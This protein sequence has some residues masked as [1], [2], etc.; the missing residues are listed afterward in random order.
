MAGIRNAY[1]YEGYEIHDMS[2][3][4]AF[5]CLIASAIDTT[6]HA[7]LIILIFSLQKLCPSDKLR[8]Q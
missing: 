4:Q 8:C 2:G 7:T 5:L 1:A 3:I 6:H